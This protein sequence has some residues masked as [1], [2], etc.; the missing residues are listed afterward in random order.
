MSNVTPAREWIKS[1]E[2]EIVKTLDSTI[3]ESGT[4]IS[5]RT[6]AC[7]ITYYSLVTPIQWYTYWSKTVIGYYKNNMFNIN[8]RNNLSVGKTI[9]YLIHESFHRYGIHHPAIKWY[10]RNRQE[11]YRHLVYRA[12]NEIEEM[13]ERSL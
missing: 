4:L 3:G 7:Q 8:R 12:G 2:I 13:Y 9:N 10:K 1:N 6:D 11:V 5:P